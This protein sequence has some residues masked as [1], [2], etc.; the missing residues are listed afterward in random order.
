MAFDAAIKKVLAKVAEIPGIGTSIVY[1]R[2]SSGS[3]NATTGDV[4]ES[5]SETTLKGVFEDVNF[6]EVAGLVQSDDRKCTIAADAISFIPS[7]ADR[8]TASGVTYQIV[9]VK[10]V[11]QAGT[12]ISYELYLRA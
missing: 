3:Y 4:R 2:V 11:E 5:V 9:R 7:T 12:Q 8:V 10:I 1:K 6:R